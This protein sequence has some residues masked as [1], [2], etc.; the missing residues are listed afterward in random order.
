L[1]LPPLHVVVQLAPVGQW[2]VQLP[3][4]HEAVQ[5]APLSQ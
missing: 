4:A 3:F 2:N 5:V 1:Q